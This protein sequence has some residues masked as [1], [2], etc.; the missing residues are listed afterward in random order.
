MKNILNLDITEIK[1][2]KENPPYKCKMCGEGDINHSQE[3]CCVCGWQDCD[4]LNENPNYFG[5]PSILSYNQYKKV[6]ENN[7][8]E[9][10]NLPFGKYKK[11]KEIFEKNSNKYGYYSK[12]QLEL[13]DKL[14]KT[15]LSK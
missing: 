5:S 8:E 12:E 10:K 2:R 11:V 15:R 13:I 4:L 6:W 1:P 14:K 3:I 9:I 7:S